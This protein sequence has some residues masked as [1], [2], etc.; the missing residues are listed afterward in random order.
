MPFFR[1]VLLPVVTLSLLVTACGGGGGGSTSNI[2]GVVVERAPGR[3]HVQGKVD[4]PGKHPPTG[5]NHNP[6]PL[7]CGFYDQQ[8]PDEYAVHSL[9]HG[10]VWIAFDPKKVPAADVQTLKSFAKQ[11]HVLV[12]PYD[13]M[14]S[15]ITV[16]A[17]EHRLE[18]PAASDARIAQFVKDFANGPQAPERGGACSGVGQPAP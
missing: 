2:S 11:D 10:A 9:E 7:T 13:G 14:D 1:K 17:W 4:Y 16:V 12:T 6:I 18:V 5:G 15:P 3:N 8:P